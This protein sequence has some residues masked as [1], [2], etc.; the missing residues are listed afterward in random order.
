MLA[1]QRQGP[2]FAADFHLLDGRHAKAVLVAGR[3]NPKGLAVV[4]PS[5]DGGN[6]TLLSPAGFGL[7]PA[8]AYIEILLMQERV[9][10][11]SELP[12]PEVPV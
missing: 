5:E 10:G 12:A 3:T 6:Q 11:Q 2:A 8:G 1:W 9:F 4:I 7:L